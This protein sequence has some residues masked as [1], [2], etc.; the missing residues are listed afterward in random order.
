MPELERPRQSD[1]PELDKLRQFISDNNLSAEL[2]ST[3]SKILQCEAKISS[4]SDSHKE[5]G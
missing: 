2:V 4:F 5:A 3:L 1:I